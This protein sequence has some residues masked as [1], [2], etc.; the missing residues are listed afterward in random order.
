MTFK[1]FHGIDRQCGDCVYFRAGAGCIRN[2][3]SCVRFETPALFCDDYVDV[4]E[5]MA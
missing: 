1:T 3:L 4:D 2:M 5:V